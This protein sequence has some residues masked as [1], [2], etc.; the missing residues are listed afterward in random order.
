[1]IYERV[2]FSLLSL[3]VQEQ[4]KAGTILENKGKD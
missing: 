4:G 1:M 2:H 3:L